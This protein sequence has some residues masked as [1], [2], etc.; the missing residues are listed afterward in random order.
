MRNVFF[1]GDAGQDR[2]VVDTLKKILWGV[3]LTEAHSLAASA[4]HEG[5]NATH[6]FNGHGS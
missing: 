3:K 1:A 4:R 6:E 2:P 5:D